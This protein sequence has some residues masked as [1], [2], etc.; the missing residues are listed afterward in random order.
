MIMKLTKILVGIGLLTTPFFASAEIW[1]DITNGYAGEYK[2]FYSSVYTG[3]TGTNY[4]LRFPEDSNISIVNTYLD[5]AYTRSNVK[6]EIYC[7]T[8]S[9][10]TTACPTTNHWT[11]ASTT[12]NGRGTFGFTFTPFTVYKTYYYKIGIYTAESGNYDKI[13]N[14]YGQ[15]TA[16]DTD[17]EYGY[18]QS[19]G[20]CSATS[21]YKFRPYY[22]FDNWGNP[23]NSYFGSVSPLNGA[24]TST[25]FNFN[26][27]YYIGAEG[28]D[29][30]VYEIFKKS[31]GEYLPTTEAGG[32]S[33]G[34]GLSVYTNSYI[35]NNTT[36]QW[37]TY[38]KNSITGERQYD[39]WR[40]VYIGNERDQDVDL[41]YST[42]TQLGLTSEELSAYCDKYHSS[43]STDLSKFWCETW[44]YLWV[45]NP[46]IIDKW[47]NYN[48]T[49]T[50]AGILGAV[51]DL[52]TVIDN[53]QEG[54]DGQSASTT[55]QFAIPVK[56][57]T[58]TI[59]ILGAS[60]IPSQVSTYLT[61]LKNIM[62]AGLYLMFGI[63]AFN[64]VST[65]I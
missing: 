28:F 9:N 59:D 37:R 25:P 43:T 7:F 34:T 16:I 15:T 14:Q 63:Y 32:L 2:S 6:I 22:T 10:Y 58:T 60:S 65:L 46:R 29:T 45:P 12:I 53:I 54:V 62:S 50:D 42:S 47:K 49:L 17:T 18:C 44:S 56:G 36:Y 48:L 21:T 8:N 35:Q 51:G 61:L 13:I 33:T 55:L 64:R 52:G 4:N 20:S 3:N 5:T 57:T 38:L 23:S 30:L 19:S 1:F 39:T 41:A 40:I 11:S 24:T 31:T 26:V 27:N